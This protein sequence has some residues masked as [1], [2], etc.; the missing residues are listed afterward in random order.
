[1]ESDDEIMSLNAAGHA[2]A[3]AAVSMLV[4]LGYRDE[5]HLVEEYAIRLMEDGLSVATLANLLEAGEHSQATIAW[6][7][8]Q[9]SGAPPFGQAPQ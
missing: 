3:V 4:K 2:V 8:A 9:A 7:I 1:M 5:L 6:V